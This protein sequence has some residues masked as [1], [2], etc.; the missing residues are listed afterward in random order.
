M[1][2][3]IGL[4]TLLV[5]SVIVLI[6]GWVFSKRY[7]LTA[8]EYLSKHPK[9]DFIVHVFTGLGSGCLIGLWIPKKI[10]LV[11]GIISAVAVAIMRYVI[12]QEKLPGHL[13][14]SGMG[15][16]LPV[17]LVIALLSYSWMQKILTLILGAISI[18]GAEAVHY[19]FPNLVNRGESF[20]EK[21]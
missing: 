14:S 19:V 5:V 1:I 21:A 16:G 20:N 8:T 17:D 12:P 4:I 3:I 7:C 13:K 9:L 10:A 18:V 6:G 11:L 2:E 15:G